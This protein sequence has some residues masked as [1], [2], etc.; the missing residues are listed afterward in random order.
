MTEII[1]EALGKTGQRGIICRGTLAEPKGFVYLLD[2]DDSCPH[3]WLFPR[4][5]AVLLASKRHALQLL[6][7]SLA[8][9][10]SGETMCMRDY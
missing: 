5:K 1:V 7:I 2:D 9:D 4:C 10:L 8:T 3:D 6:F